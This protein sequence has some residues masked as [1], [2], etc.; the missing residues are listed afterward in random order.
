MIQFF[1]DAVTV[2]SAKEWIVY[3]IVIGGVFGF[4]WMLME[5]EQKREVNRGQRK[6]AVHP[7]RRKGD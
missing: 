2:L 4:L 3:I 7:R 1:H 6:Q 5:A